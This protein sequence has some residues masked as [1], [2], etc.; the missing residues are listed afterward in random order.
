MVAFLALMN[1]PEV[2]MGCLQC[3]CGEG[4]MGSEPCATLV[5]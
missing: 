3:L 5:R 1:W 4:V 2:E